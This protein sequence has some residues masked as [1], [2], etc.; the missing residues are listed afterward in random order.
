M[1]NKFRRRV[2]VVKSDGSAR[3][4]QGGQRPRDG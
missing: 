2:G 1:L 4:G 3:V